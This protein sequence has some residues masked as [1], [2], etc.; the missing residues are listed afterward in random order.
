MNTNQLFKRTLISSI[1]MATSLQASAEGGM[2]QSLTDF[3]VNETS[4]MKKTG[5][6]VGMWASAGVTGNSNGKTNA[7]VLFN[8]KVNSFDLDQLNFYI[9]RGVNTEGD[10]WDIGGRMDFMYGRDANNTQ[11]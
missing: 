5:I 9:E 4:I 2:V 11:A 6:E 10:S 7:P 3:D 8:D 1:L